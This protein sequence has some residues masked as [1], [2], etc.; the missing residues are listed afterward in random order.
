MLNKILIALVLAVMA[1]CI[2]VQTD[3]AFA[4]KKADSPSQQIHKIT[5]TIPQSIDE[6]AQAKIIEKLLGME[7]QRFVYLDLSINFSSETASSKPYSVMINGKPHE[8]G[9]KGC[10]IGVLPMGAGVGYELGPVAD[11]NHLLVSVYTGNRSAF[12]YNDVS[13]EYVNSGSE[14]QFRVR[15]F[16]HVLGNSIPTATALQLR[17]FNPPF[18][19]VR[20]VFARPQ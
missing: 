11:Y 5:V 19:V 4:S 12:P 6:N 8:D 18:E 16:F 20:S 2:P 14:S 17:P 10:S 3:E 15:G 9:G 1:F 7:K 13:C